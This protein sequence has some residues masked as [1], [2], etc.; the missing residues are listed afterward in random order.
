MAALLL[1]VPAMVTNL[2]AQGGGAPIEGRVLNGT[3][4]APVPNA[5]VNYVR[6]S[7]GMTPLAQAT[8]GPDGRFRLEGIPPA[9]GPAPALLRVDHQ[10][11]TYSQ[12]MLPG[13]PSTGVEIQVYDASSDRAAFSVVEQAIFLHPAGDSLSVLEQIIIQNQ[14]SPPR[15]YVNPEGT[16]LFTLPPTAR[17]GL[18]VTVNGPGGMPIGQEP[19]PRGGA[20]QFAIDYP[21][22]PGDTQIRLEYSMDYASP[23]QFEKPIDLRADQTHIVT[24]GPEVEI[25]GDGVTALDRDPSSGFVGYLVNQPGTTL[26]V[27]V[28][29]ESPLQEGAQTELSEGGD[30]S[31]LAPSPPPVAGQR[32]WIM[33]AAGLLLLGGLVYLYRM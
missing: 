19:R 9:A 4:G 2:H 21:I 25:Q 11:A 26:S 3:T 18:R 14:T 1:V 16:Y 27:S 6:M 22:R 28:S 31:T 5:Q 32:L 7:Q 17:E 15:A 23:L 12:P 10:G 20:N 13:A 24:T 8:T 29:G 33:A 30:S